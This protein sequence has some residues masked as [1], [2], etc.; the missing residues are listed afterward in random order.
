MPKETIKPYTDRTCAQIL[1]IENHSLEKITV[2]LFLPSF[3]GNTADVKKYIDRNLYSNQNCLVGI[4]HSVPLVFSI[5]EE[6]LPPSIQVTLLEKIMQN[7]EPLHANLQYTQPIHTTHICAAKKKKHL[8]I[9]LHIISIQSLD[10]IHTHTRHRI[11]LG[12]QF[13]SF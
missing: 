4:F 3:W 11:V 6:E 1:R 7:L 12:T 8:S 9:K 5:Y 2:L 10:F 13:I